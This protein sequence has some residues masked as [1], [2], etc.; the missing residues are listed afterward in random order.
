MKF[1][2]LTEMV[3]LPR[4]NQDNIT[5]YAPGIWKRINNNVVYY[6]NEPA[7]KRMESLH[8]LD[9]PAVEWYDGFDNQFYINGKAYNETEYWELVNKFKEDAGT[10]GDLLDV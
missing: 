7:C 8:R 6:C 3:I 4:N 5:L 1:S 2:Q 10:A 9:G